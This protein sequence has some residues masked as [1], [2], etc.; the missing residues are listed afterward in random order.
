M[1]Y[2]KNV[3]FRLIRM[4]ILCFIVCT[5]A[6]SCKKDEPTKEVEP[7]VNLALD[8]LVA[9]KRHIVTFEEIFITAFAKGKNITYKWKTNHGSMTGQDSITVK[10][11]ACWSCVGL[12]TVECTVSNDCGNIS[13][14]IMISVIMGK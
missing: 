7:S 2:N 10:Y 9:T 6:T 14:T 4:F 5:T 8:S 12:N 1:V 3:H 11:W 13:D